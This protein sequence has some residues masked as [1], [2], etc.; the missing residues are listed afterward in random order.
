[1]KSTTNL[2]TKKIMTVFKKFD[3]KKSGLI[4]IEEFYLTI[5]ILIA[6]KVFFNFKK[7]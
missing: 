5:C 2:S 6:I 7:I 1:M 4:E 3:V